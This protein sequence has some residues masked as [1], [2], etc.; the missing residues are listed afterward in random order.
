MHPEFDFVEPTLIPELLEGEART[1]QALDEARARAQKILQEA[2][3]EARA[4]LQ[5]AREDAQEAAQAYLEQAHRELE[6]TAKERRAAM[7]ESLKK[8]EI[9]GKEHLKEGV[10]FV[11]RLVLGEA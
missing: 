1:L 4:L 5:K 7:T 3:D 10:H 8:V 2:E 9:L 11:T 6:A